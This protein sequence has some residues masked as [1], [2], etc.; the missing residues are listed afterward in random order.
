MRKI[1]ALSG[2]VLGFLIL[3]GNVL[4]AGEVVIVTS[5]PK[6]LF[7]TYKREFEARNPY[8]TITVKSKKTSAA[9]AYIRETAFKLDSDIM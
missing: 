1:L 7:E 5:F 4:A 6:E 2:L 3:A 9:V 8:I